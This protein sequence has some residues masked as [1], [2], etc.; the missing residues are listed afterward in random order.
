MVVLEHDGEG[1]LQ[2]AGRHELVSVTDPATNET[3]VSGYSFSNRLR[4]LPT[5]SV[6]KV[7]VRMSHDD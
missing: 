2:L 3:K 6:H 7:R 1:R 5:D 4:V